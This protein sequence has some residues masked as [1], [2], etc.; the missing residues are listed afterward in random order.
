[1]R[2]KLNRALAQIIRNRDLEGH[3]TLEP[4]QNK[5]GKKEEQTGEKKSH[6]IIHFKTRTG[7]FKMLH[8]A[9]EQDE[10]VSGSGGSGGSSNGLGE[11]T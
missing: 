11:I 10:S 5:A 9:S 2:A 1:M 6:D 8:D 4:Q 7:D 3:S